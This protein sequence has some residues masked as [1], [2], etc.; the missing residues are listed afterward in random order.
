MLSTF[1]NIQA[2]NVGRAITR[3]RARTDQQIE[4]LSSGLRV[5]RA[6]DDAAGLSVSE[7]MRAQLMRLGANVRNS[8]QANDLLRVAEGSLQEAGQILQRMRTLAMQAADSALTDPQR[9]I[10]ATEFSHGRAAIDRIAQATVYNNRILLAGFAELDAASS[11]AVAQAVDTGVVSVAL[12][13]AEKGTYTFIDSPGDATVTLGNGLATQTLSLGT[14][15]DGDRVAAGTRVVA[16]FD[17]LGVQVT[18]AGVG[19]TKPEGVGDYVE[20]DLDGKSLTVIEGDGGLFQVGPSPRDEDQLKFSLP[21]L[22]ASGDALDLDKISL[23][24]LSSAR[25][26]LTR[27]DEA[28]SRVSL[29]RGRIGGLMNRLDYSIS[30]SENEIENMTDSES[31]IRDADVAQESTDFS[32]SLILTQASSAMLTQAFANSRQALR[33]L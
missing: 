7:G 9:E 11:T 20:G 19:A 18:L 8:E 25:D 10:L 6:E 5:K 13:G 12:S 1:N 3:N 16:N 24:S 14:L 15:L 27:L 22:R 21:D 4:T 26:A 23:A 28:I 32:R 33:L 29:E 30:F 2:I 31:S 17:R